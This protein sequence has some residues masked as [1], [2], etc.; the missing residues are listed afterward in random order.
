[1]RTISKGTDCMLLQSWQRISLCELISSMTKFQCAWYPQHIF[2]ST[3]TECL[4]SITGEYACGWNTE[5]PLTNS[6][7][8]CLS[9][10]KMNLSILRLQWQISWWSCRKFKWTVTIRNFAQKTATITWYSQPTSSLLQN[11]QSRYFGTAH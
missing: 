8:A 11:F 6:Q 1:M 3:I 5:I 2:L 10:G 7:L 9:S 4:G